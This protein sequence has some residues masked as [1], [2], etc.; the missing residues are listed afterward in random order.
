MESYY[1]IIELT[2]VF[3][4]VLALGLYEL[5]SLRRSQAADRKRAEAAE[6]DG[7]QGSAPP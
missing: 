7:D 4:S 1:G 2:L 3:G 5:I 6:K